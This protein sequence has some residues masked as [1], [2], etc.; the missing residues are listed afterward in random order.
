MQAYFWHF[1]G[2]LKGPLKMVYTLELSLFL[3]FFLLQQ[4]E[5]RLSPKDVSCVINKCLP[6]TTH[7]VR[8]VAYSENGTIL[9]K[10]KQLTVQTSAPPDQPVL[11]VRLVVWQWTKREICQLDFFEKNFFYEFLKAIGQSQKLL[12]KKLEK[13]SIKDLNKIS[14][15]VLWTFKAL[16]CWFYI[17]RKVFKLTSRHCLGH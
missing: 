17:K 13:T 11:S 7:F 1:W 8:L 15:T 3:F 2:Q 6:G 14:I 9:E 5:V 16:I 10:S 12:N 4:R